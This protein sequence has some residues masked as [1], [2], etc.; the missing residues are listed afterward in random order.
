MHLSSQTLSFKLLLLFAL[1]L[2]FCFCAAST[3]LTTY[4]TFYQ[5]NCNFLVTIVLLVDFFIYLNWMFTFKSAHGFYINEKVF[6]LHMFWTCLPH[7][8]SLKPITGTSRNTFKYPS[9]DVRTTCNSSTIF[10]KFLNTVWF[11]T[12]RL[13][14]SSF[15]DY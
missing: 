4:L 13:F 8:L 14:C 3:L 2:N 1:D 11:V 10:L 7:S 9:S 12:L 6:F 15:P 5:I